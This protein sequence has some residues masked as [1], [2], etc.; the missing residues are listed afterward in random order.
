MKSDK[1]KRAERLFAKLEKKRI[2]DKFRKF[3]SNRR[4]KPYKREKS[5]EAGE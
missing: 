3:H 4:P 5:Y 2:I 1:E